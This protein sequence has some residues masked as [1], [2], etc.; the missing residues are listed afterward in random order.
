MARILSKRSI[1]RPPR[2]RR[3]AAARAH[4]KPLQAPSPSP[5]RHRTRDRHR[6]RGRRRREARPRSGVAANRLARSVVRI[7]VDARRGSRPPPERVVADSRHR[8][9]HRGTTQSPAMPPLW[10]PAP[11]GC[12]RSCGAADPAGARTSGVRVGHRHPH[13]RRLDHGVR[14][15]VPGSRCPTAA[16]RSRPTFT[17]ACGC[18]ACARGRG[19]TV[20]RVAPVARAGRRHARR[21]CRRTSRSRAG[22]TR[23]R[24]VANPTRK[25]TARSAQAEDGRAGVAA[26]TGGGGRGRRRIQARTC[27][28]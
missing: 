1:R 7:D 2:R 12:A 9:H 13:R 21:A 25:P 28:V 14:P 24:Q 17:L 19:S 20:D 16:S 15:D 11:R 10:R 8:H 18:S 6:P 5:A 22:S 27:A 4:G 26:T 23:T 3:R